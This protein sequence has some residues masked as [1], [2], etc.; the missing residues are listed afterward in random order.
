MA[1]NNPAAPAPAPAPAL[2]HPFPELPLLGS[3]M[4]FPRNELGDAYRRILEEEEGFSVVPIYMP[5]PPPSLAQLESQPQVPVLSGSVGGQNSLPRGESSHLYD[6]SREPLEWK[7]EVLGCVDSAHEDSA[8]KTTMQP[9][10]EE[11]EY[12]EKKKKKTKSGLL[13]GGPSFRPVFSDVRQLCVSVESRNTT[14]A[15]RSSSAGP[16][17]ID[18]SGIQV[19]HTHKESPMAISAS[20][21]LESGSFAVSLLKELVA[22][23]A[24][25]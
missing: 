21:E 11:E 13:P 20:F 4:F 3:R 19:Q 18:R 17:D 10:R 2:N 6:H 16:A 8:K 14:Q 1:V 23:D 25:L 22:S 24:I 5:T 7:V 15:R 12:S 9:K